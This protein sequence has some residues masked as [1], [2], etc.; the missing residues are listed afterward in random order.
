MAKKKREKEKLFEAVQFK[1]FEQAKRA[2]TLAKINQTRILIGM[3]IA[4]ISTGFTAY[5]IFG[6]AEQPME[7]FSYAFLLAIPAYLI[8]GGIVKALKQAWK[9]AKIGWFLIPVF[10]I[11]L[12]I[13]LVALI[14]SFFAFFCIPA[15]FVVGNYI[16]HKNTLQAAKSYLAQC[17]HAM[18]PIEE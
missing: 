8:G 17:G 13:G 5:A 18:S 14:W 2:V 4:L 9:I 16:Q 1:D 11:D 10:P 7:Y 3:V 12:A 6:N 15:F